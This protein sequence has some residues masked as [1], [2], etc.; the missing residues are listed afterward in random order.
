MILSASPGPTTRAPIVRILA[1]L[2]SLV[3]SA[4]KQSEQSAA[5]MPFTLFATI[6][7]PIP[8]PQLNSLRPQSSPAPA[9]DRSDPVSEVQ[10]STL[11]PLVLEI[12]LGE[13]IARY[14]LDNGVWSSEGERVTVS[15]GEGRRAF[16]AVFSLDSADSDEAV[17]TLQPTNRSEPIYVLA[18]RI[19]GRNIR[20]P[21]NTI[22]F[23]MTYDP[24]P[25]D[26]LEEYFRSIEKG[27]KS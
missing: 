12:A 18:F 1:S 14:A 20:G 17:A 4:E 2:C 15:A 21:L 19:C 25:V 9:F 5:R 7:T 3:I 22:L 13:C 27:S 11:A 16:Y 24:N 10:N 8:V 23:T 26:S 6:E